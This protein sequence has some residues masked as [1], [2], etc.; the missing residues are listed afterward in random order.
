MLNLN[1]LNH[2]RLV[3]DT[4]SFAEAARLA[5]ITQPALSNSIRTLE[6]RMGVQL[7]DRSE[8][9]V[10]LT[11][12]GRDLLARIDAVLA[13]A[14]NLEKEV[15]Y[16]AQGLSGQLRIGLTAQSAA[17]IGG[18]ILGCWQASNGRMSCDVVVAD[19]L[20]LLD[21]LR[22]ETLDLVI[23]D[24]RDL[25]SYPSDL[26]TV[27]LPSHEGRAFCRSGHP[28]LALEGVQ[29][30]DLLQYRFAGS[31]FPTTLIHDLA[32]RF[33]LSHPGLVEQA[34]ACD[35]I[36]VV[37]DAVLHSDLILLTTRRCV[38]NELQA[39]LVVE[40]PIDL[41]TPTTWHVVT[42]K[43]TVSHPALAS[44]LEAIAIATRED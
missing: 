32:R 42:L 33:G 30:H 4:G 16:L 36:A 5:F 23:A 40:L 3:A 8:R 6:E 14:Q 38:R 41:M 18:A 11:P 27:P 20:Q 44:L 37:R 21:K 25:P 7:L 15:T 39:E 29:F 31:H 2:F 35:N 34:I 1:Q 22:A 17:S 26:D 28:I 24:G 13:E 9:P 19:S 12:L 10:R 43:N